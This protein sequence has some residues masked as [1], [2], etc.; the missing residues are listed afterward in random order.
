MGLNNW[1]EGTTALK[2]FPCINSSNPHTKLMREV[3]SWFPFSVRTPSHREVV[4]VTQL[5]S[6]RAGI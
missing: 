3:V 5:V 4:Q 1:K 2:V 6:D